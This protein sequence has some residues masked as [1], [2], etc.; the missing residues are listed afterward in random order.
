MSLNNDLLAQSF[1]TCLATI[2]W[3]CNPLTWAFYNP[4]MRGNLT[5]TSATTTAQI[6][7]VS[8]LL[9]KVTLLN[10]WSPNPCLETGVPS[11]GPNISTEIRDKHAG[12]HARDHTLIIP[13]SFT[14]EGHSAVSTVVL[15]NFTL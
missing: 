14:S 1:I 7:A 12:M 5:Y 8:S 9:V 4:M 10:P 11:R 3:G 15:G 2:Y 6:T 13:S